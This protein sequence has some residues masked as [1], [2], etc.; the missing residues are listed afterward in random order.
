MTLIQGGRVVDA[1]HYVG[2]TDILIDEGTIM[3]VDAGLAERADLRHVSRIAAE[4]LLVVPGF[5]DLHAH[6]REPGFEYKETIAT[7]TAAAVAGGFTT[8][9]CMP[10]TKPVNDHIAVTG[11]IIERTKATASSHV[12]PIGAVTLGSAGR[13]FADFR[14]LKEAGCVAVSDD[15]RPVMSDEIMRRAMQSAAELDLPVIDHCEDMRSSGCGCMNEGPVSRSMGWRGMPGNAEYRMIARD[16][17]LARETGA[18]LHI[19]HLS[20]A[21]GVEMVRKAKSDGVRITAEVCPHHFTL[22]DEAVRTYGA[23]AKMNPPLRSERDRT[24]LIEG[25]LDGTID[26]IATDHAP[27]AEY[28]KQWGMDRAPFGV[29]GLET[30]LGLTLRLVRQG[31]LTLERAITCL[32]SAPAAIFGLPKGTLEPGASADL[33]LIDP[34]TSWTVDPERFRSKGRNTPFSGYALTGQVVR[35]L[36]AGMTV[37]QRSETM[38]CTIAYEEHDD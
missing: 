5:V 1:G 37:Y 33:T 19:A 28:E 18:R 38:R 20:T 36:V 6:L 30:A 26:A 22:T 14:A 32:T 27:H 29:V 17:R 16:I 9:C 11:W 4:G 24:A 8:V 21:D 3:A 34:D 23:N 35:T 15:G 10:N 25:L 2:V 7:G 13:E 12:Y 31:R